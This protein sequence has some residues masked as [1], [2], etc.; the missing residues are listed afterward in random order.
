MNPLAFFLP[1]VAGWAMAWGVG[2][3]IAWASRP[4]RDAHPIS[5]FDDGHLP[6][7]LESMP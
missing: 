4:V 2:L 3:G 1:A 6:H 7:R 5:L